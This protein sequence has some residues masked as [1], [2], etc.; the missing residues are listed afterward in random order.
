MSE[1]LPNGR[2]AVP[3]RRRGHHQIEASMRL[4]LLLHRDRNRASAVVGRVGLA[5]HRVHT[6]PVVIGSQCRRRGGCDCPA[7]DARS[8]GKRPYFASPYL[9]VRIR[10]RRVR[11]PVEAHRCRRRGLVPIILHPH[12]WLNRPSRTN[13]TGVSSN[14]GCVNPQVRTERRRRYSDL[15][16]IRAVVSG[17]GLP[18]SPRPHTLRSNTSLPSRARSEKSTPRW[19]RTPPASTPRPC[20]PPC[21]EFVI[22]A[23]VDR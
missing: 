16:R 18:R 10:Y 11:R 12:A 15:H 9:C 4:L 13:T 8:S 5:C 3:Y 17:A 20:P 14:Y 2:L 22:V 23:S 6:R 7:A 1:R 21:P 19:S